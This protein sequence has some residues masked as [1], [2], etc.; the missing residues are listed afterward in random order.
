L[1]VTYQD[2]CHLAHGQHVRSQPRMLLRAIPGVELVEMRAADRCC[3]SAGIYNVTNYDLS[4]QVL[5]EKMG[6]V[7]A[8][9]PDVIVSANPGC[10]IQLQHG[11]RQYGVQ[12]EVLHI[13][14]LLDR[15]YAPS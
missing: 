12:A 11:C 6:N 8:T 7:A 2:P 4:M 9:H 10:I 14:D 15:A 13:V 3:G 1:R 5:A